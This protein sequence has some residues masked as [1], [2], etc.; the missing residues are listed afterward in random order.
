MNRTKNELTQINEELLKQKETVEKQNEELANQSDKLASAHYEIMFKNNQLEYQNAQIT[1]SIKYASMI[2]K[3]VLTPQFN[4]EKTF[5][6][7]LIFYK[8][9][10]ILSGDFYWFKEFYGKYY[11]ACADCTGH[12]FSGAMMSMLGISFL[13][14]LT[15]HHNDRNVTPAI[16]LDKLRLKVVETLHQTGEIGQIRD[17]MDIG[18]CM[19]DPENNKLEFA[20]AYNILYQIVNTPEGTFDLIEHKGDRMPVGIYDKPEPFTNYSFDLTEG[21]TFYLSTDGYIDQ[22]GGPNKKKL[23]KQ[24][25]KNLLLSIQHLNLTEQR[26]YI[27]EFLKSWIGTLEQVDDI[28]VVGIKLL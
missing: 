11:F 24:N 16:I 8:P 26:L 14:E 22:F 1:D 21:D 27:K 19:F 3:A 4:L 12:G 20:G 25:F 13:N 15:H 7:H 10:E 28:T 17:G 6:D 9:K 2:Q 5:K 23:N 18:L